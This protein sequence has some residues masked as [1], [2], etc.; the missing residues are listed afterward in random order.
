MLWCKNHVS[1]TEE[2]IRA[3]RIDFESFA[4]TL[5][6]KNNGC[7]LGFAYPVALHKLDGFWPVEF[8][9]IVKQALRVGCYL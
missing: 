7:S 5:D 3:S 4:K 8:I 1:R 6:C 9:E 2:C